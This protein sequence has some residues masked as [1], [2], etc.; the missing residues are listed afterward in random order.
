MPDRLVVGLHP[1]REL[2]RAGRPLHRIAVAAGRTEGAVLDELLELART[3]RVPVDRVD[4]D[5]LDSRAA[6]L[7]HQGVVA[8]APAFEHGDLD[9]VLAGA[10]AAGE[11]PLLVALD[12]VTDPHNLGSICR[13]AEAVGAH[14]VV[15]TDRRSAPVTPVAEKA[16]AGALAHLPVV[17][18]TNLVRT[19]EAIA[20]RPVWS[21]GL[22]AEGTVEVADSHLLADPVVL[23]VGA[24]GSGLSRLTRERCDQLVRL[25]MRGRVGSLN[26]S[27]ATAVALYA[28]DAARHA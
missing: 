14:A 13:T 8:T 6:G 11:A 4:R 7:V 27:V 16:A 18:V 2:L 5:E 17:R 28:I 1:V 23:V 19:L 24:E 21:L 9:E 10:E 25:P 3:A 15:V 22:D 20:D 12:G 26:A